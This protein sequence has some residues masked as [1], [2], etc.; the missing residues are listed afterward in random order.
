MNW[1]GLAQTV[2]ITSAAII[3]SL[4]LFAGFLLV[5]AGVPPLKLFQLMYASSLGTD[6]AR[7]NTLSRAAP[8]FASII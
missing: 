2:T 8:P 6:F 7:Q 4:L 1:R 5:F 3:S